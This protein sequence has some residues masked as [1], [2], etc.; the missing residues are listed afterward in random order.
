MWRRACNLSAQKVGQEE[1]YDFK[2]SLGDIGRP[3]L[4][5]QNKS[6][7]LL[8]E[9]LCLWESMETQSK[10]GCQGPVQPLLA[11]SLACEAILVPCDRAS[12][13]GF[14]L[15]PFLIGYPSL[16]MLSYALSLGPFSVKTQDLCS[17]WVRSQPLRL[18]PTPCPYSIRQGFP[19]QKNHKPGRKNAYVS[20]LV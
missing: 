12:I 18:L 7:E 9:S 3:G 17:F 19:P 13:P 1:A 6:T 5:K 10:H 4:P 20:K 11:T 14:P 8:Q 15:R 16:R 2:L